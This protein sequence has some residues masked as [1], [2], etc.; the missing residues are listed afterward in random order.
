MEMLRLASI[1]D[2]ED[3]WEED[4]WEEDEEELDDY[5]KSITVSEERLDRLLAIEK[6]ARKLAEAAEYRVNHMF[7]GE[8]SSYYVRN[9]DLVALRALLEI[10]K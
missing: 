5:E 8:T 4:D 1:W 3:D 6:V 9:D 10:G 7:T 2:A